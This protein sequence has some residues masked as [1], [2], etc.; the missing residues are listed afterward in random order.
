MYGCRKSDEAIVAVKP[1]KGEGGNQTQTVERRAEAKGNAY[2]QSTHRAQNRIRVAQA[3]ARIR[4]TAAAMRR[5][6]PRWEPYAG[7]PHVR[8]CAGGARQ[9][10]SLPR[11]AEKSRVDTRPRPAVP[12]QIAAS[13]RVGTAEPRPWI[14]RASWPPLPTL[15][16]RRIHMPIY[17]AA[18][19]MA[20]PSANSR[21]SITVGTSQT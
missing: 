11:P 21:R 10:A 17:S 5:L 15:H 9:L 14:A 1:T 3:L 6:E 16:R 13:G 7:K 19:A 4:R 20:R 12:T 18:C 2:Q 8:F